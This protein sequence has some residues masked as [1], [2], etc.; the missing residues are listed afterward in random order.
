MFLGHEDAEEHNF[1][2]MGRKMND[3]DGGQ[4]VHIKGGAATF[5]APPT[6]RKLSL[7]PPFVQDHSRPL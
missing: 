6:Q 2:N 4:A 1:L 3:D 5:Q 7:P